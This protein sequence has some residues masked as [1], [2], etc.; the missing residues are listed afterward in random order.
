MFVGF[1]HFCFLVGFAVVAVAVA[2]AVV[3]VAAVAVAALTQNGVFLIPFCA[4]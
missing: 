3:A 2:V 1:Y 4:L